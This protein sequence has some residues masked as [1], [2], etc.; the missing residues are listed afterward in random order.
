VV[1]KAVYTLCI[2][3][4]GI[5]GHAADM[6]SIIGAV[7]SSATLLALNRIGGL[8]YSQKPSSKLFQ[9]VHVVYRTW[10]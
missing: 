8:D 9:L 2:E 7:A 10:M 6:K 1:G 5:F 3:V 4:K